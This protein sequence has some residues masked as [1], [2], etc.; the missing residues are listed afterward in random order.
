MQ[1]RQIYSFEGETKMAKSLFQQ[2]GDHWTKSGK[3]D[4][5][6]LVL[7]DACIQRVASK[8]CDKDALTRFVSRSGIHMPKITRI[9]R[10]A[11]GNDLSYKKDATKAAGG[12]MKHN[13]KGDEGYVL[14]NTYAHV[15]QALEQG[16]AFNDPALQK[17]I[18]PAKKETNKDKADLLAAYKTRAEK[19]A[20]ENNITMSAL[21]ATLKAKATKIEV[22]N[23][24]EVHRVA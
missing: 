14:G 23:G 22:I 6:G 12:V 3:L 1:W 16:K 18:A 11:F 24:M 4:K 13:W 20:K 7:L 10:A 9:I 17:A 19:W 8:D 2:V 5:A 21:I 15:M